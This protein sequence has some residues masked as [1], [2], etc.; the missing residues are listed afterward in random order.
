[1]FNSVTVQP[2][3]AARGELLRGKLPKELKKRMVKVLVWSVALYASETWTLRNLDI[4][5]LE[6]LEM[7]IWRQMERI[8][9]TEHETN[10]QLLLTVGNNAR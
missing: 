8:I 7:W 6:A 2:D 4:K 5:R 3:E 10:E 1:M 9:W